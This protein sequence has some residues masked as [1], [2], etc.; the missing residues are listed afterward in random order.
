MLILHV[1]KQVAARWGEKSLAHFANSVQ[2]SI[3][4]AIWAICLFSI[5]FTTL[6]NLQQKEGI[7]VNPSN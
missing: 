7:I 5:Q 2:L 1:N 4:R 6:A 3:F